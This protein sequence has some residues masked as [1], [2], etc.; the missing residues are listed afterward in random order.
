MVTREKQE[1]LH[2]GAAAIKATL[3]P[4]NY[5][6]SVDKLSLL[7]HSPKRSHPEP[8]KRHCE[9]NCNHHPPRSNSSGLVFCIF[10]RQRDAAKASHREENKPCYLKP[11]LVKHAPERSRSSTRR[12]SNCSDCATALGMLPRQTSRHSG[13]DSQLSC[14]GNLAHGLDFNSLWRYN[15]AACRRANR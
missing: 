4:L 15:G 2:S 5:S 14:R 13:N 7:L 1:P 10:V 11:K 9:T 8:G 3:F 12:R 6:G